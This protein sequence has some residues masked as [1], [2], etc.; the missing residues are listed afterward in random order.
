MSQGMAVFGLEYSNKH[1]TIDTRQGMFINLVAFY[2]Q[3]IHRLEEQYCFGKANTAYIFAGFSDQQH[4]PW[5][6]THQ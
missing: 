6:V 5:E 1:Y 3:G 4:V 2:H